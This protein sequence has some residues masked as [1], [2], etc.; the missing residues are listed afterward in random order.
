M[1]FISGSVIF[2]RILQK[3]KGYYYKKNH[4]VSVSSMVYRM[5]RNG[6][7]LAS[8]CILA[9]MVLVMLSSTTCLYFG[10]EDSIDTRYP[11]DININTSLSETT[12]VSYTHLPRLPS[13][14]VN[15]VPYSTG[16]ACLYA[17]W[18][19]AASSGSSVLHI[20]TW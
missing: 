17:A 5:K 4:F 19:Y 7:G 16:I 9:T 1:I 20:I 15:S 3:N 18:K 10:V 6:A 2:C 14:I 12:S 8:I 11:N 13:L